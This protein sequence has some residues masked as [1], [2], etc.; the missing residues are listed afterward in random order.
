MGSRAPP[1]VPVSEPDAVPVPVPVPVPDPP[2]ELPPE[3]VPTPDVEPVLVVPAES[4]ADSVPVPESEVPDP[5]D[6]PQAHN[7]A[8]APISA[9]PL[10]MPRAYP[11]PGARGA[12]PRQPT[13]MALI[14]TSA[15][16][17]SPAACTAARAG[18]SSAKRLA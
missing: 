2:P 5:P 4:V 3:S 11:S 13:A 9:H 15:P 10:R 18:G 6:P 16:L 1:L 8:P 7:S 12:G 17:G 14:S